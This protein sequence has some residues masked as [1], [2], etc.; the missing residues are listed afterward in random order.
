MTLIKLAA[1]I[2]YRNYELLQT[3]A[4]FEIYT[5]KNKGRSHPE[6]SDP[7]RRGFCSGFT[8]NDVSRGFSSA[9]TLTSTKYVVS[10]SARIMHGQLFC[11]LISMSRLKMRPLGFTRNKRLRQTAIIFS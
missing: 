8:K 1:S 10:W 3:K 6:A 5:A 7:T 9:K 2:D 4:Y 11:Y